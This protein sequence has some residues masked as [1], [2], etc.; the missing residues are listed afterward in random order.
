MNS[1]CKKVAFGRAS[2]EGKLNAQGRGNIFHRF[3][4][5]NPSVS[6]D[7]QRNTCKF[8]NSKLTLCWEEVQNCNFI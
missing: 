3:I 5:G 1:R 2:G 8:I 6:Q 7:L 4:N